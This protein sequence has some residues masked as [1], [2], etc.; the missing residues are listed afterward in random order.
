M[1]VDPHQ[2]E[3][4][5]RKDSLSSDFLM[6]V[7]SSRG[8]RG[9]DFV[10]I[11]LLNFN[12]SPSLKFW[13]LCPNAILNDCPCIEVQV[14]QNPKKIMYSILAHNIGRWYKVLW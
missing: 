14:S 6:P 5:R 8:I 3:A 9:F 1:V 2:D 4:D 13:G 11:F 10:A 7:L 12:E